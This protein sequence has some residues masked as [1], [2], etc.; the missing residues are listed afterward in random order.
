MGGTLML[1]LPI[2]GVIAIGVL[3]VTALAAALFIAATVVSVV[4]AAGTKKTPS[5]RKEA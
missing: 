1:A 3:V 2:I 4:F 5:P